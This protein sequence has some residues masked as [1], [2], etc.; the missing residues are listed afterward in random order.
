MRPPATVLRALSSG[1]F[2]DRHV[3]QR[4]FIHSTVKRRLNGGKLSPSLPS[5]AKLPAR[6]PE[7]LS[8]VQAA[9]GA[10]RALHALTWR[11]GGTK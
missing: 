7:R 11:Q 3:L 5:R 9:A 8:R 4:R 1:M 6:A 10:L 2:G